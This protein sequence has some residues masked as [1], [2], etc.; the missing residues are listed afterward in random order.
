MEL[1]QEINDGLNES[2]LK[3]YR[4]NVVLKTKV[5]GFNLYLETN[6]TAVSK[7]DAI[8]MV[9]GYLDKAR[10]EFDDVLTQ[11]WSVQTITPI[12]PTS[13][14]QHQKRMVAKK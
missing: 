7:N 12:R 2:R 4:Y 11:K 3:E 10:A 6:I 5:G 1:L 14:M 13:K 8:Q 9:R